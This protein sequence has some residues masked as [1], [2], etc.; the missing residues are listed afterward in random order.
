[1]TRKPWDET[2]IFKQHQ[3]QNQNS[4][5]EEALQFTRNLKQPPPDS[6]KKSIRSKGNVTTN[7]RS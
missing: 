4:F 1:M 2:R 6:P 3:I 5:L 7:P